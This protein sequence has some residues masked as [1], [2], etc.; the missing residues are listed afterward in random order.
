MLS[1]AMAVHPFRRRFNFTNIPRMASHVRYINCIPLHTFANTDTPLAMA[2]IPST[3]SFRDLSPSLGAIENGTL[4]GVFLFGIE[5]LQT[6]HYYRNFS[7]DSKLLKAVVRR[8]WEGQ[9]IC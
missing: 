5:T 9:D 4:L 6:F 8:G 3:L 2:S 7:Q 1:P